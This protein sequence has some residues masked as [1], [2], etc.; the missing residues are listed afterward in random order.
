MN[1]HTAGSVSIYLQQQGL[2][3]NEEGVSNTDCYTHVIQD[4]TRTS[5]H[6]RDSLRRRRSLFYSRVVGLQL[7]LGTGLRPRWTHGPVSVLSFTEHPLPL[8][9]HDKTLSNSTETHA[10]ISLVSDTSCCTEC[11]SLLHLQTFCS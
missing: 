10:F 8:K 11:D 7:F 1:V 2:R 4:I 5:A 3:T 6:L 9:P